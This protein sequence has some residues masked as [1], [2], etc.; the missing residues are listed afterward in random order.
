MLCINVYW[1]IAW[2][3]LNAYSVR[4][5]L[6]LMF[7]NELNI[8]WCEVRCRELTKPLDFNFSNL[9]LFFFCCDISIVS[10]KQL[11]PQNSFRWIVFYHCGKFYWIKTQKT[12]NFALLQNSSTSS[13]LLFFSCSYISWRASSSKPSNGA[14]SFVSDSSQLERQIVTNYFFHC[15]LFVFT[16][17][18]C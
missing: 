6:L 4:T 14:C 15:N 11:L 9:R 10:P 7:K 13:S 5:F 1:A 18:T 8:V 12:K 16:A 2:I 17:T 3:C